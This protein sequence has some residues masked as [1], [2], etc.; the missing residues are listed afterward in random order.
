[1]DKDIFRN[2][3]TQDLQNNIQTY[4][5]FIESIPLIKLLNQKKQLA[6][7]YSLIPQYHPPK[8]YII[9]KG[10]KSNGLYILKKGDV[11]LESNKQY[12]RN[13]SSKDIFGERSLLAQSE[14]NNDVIANSNC[15]VYFV[16]DASLV[17]IFG[18]NMIF[19]LFKNNVTNAF[20]SNPLFKGLRVKYIK[21]ILGLFNI[22]ECR[23][24]EIAYHK[25]EIKSSTV[26][27]IIEGGLYDENK[28]IV[29]KKGEILFDKE[30]LFQSKEVL[31]YDIKADPD[32]LIYEANTDEIISELGMSI[33]QAIQKS[34]TYS[35]KKNNEIMNILS[36]NQL[37]LLV[38]SSEE[39]SFKPKE[40]IFS[41]ESTNN[42]LYFLNSGHVI[43]ETEFF[44]KKEKKTVSSLFGSYILEYQTYQQ[45]A[46]VK[47][48]ANVICL[49]K[50]KLKKILGPNM[51]N[52]FKNIVL[53]R[54]CCFQVTDF[55]FINELYVEN[56][57]K[58]SLVTSSRSN[59]LYGI[60]RMNKKLVVYDG[61]M[62]KLSLEKE[63]LN[64]L[65]HPFVIKLHSTLQVQYFL[66]FLMEYIHGVTLYSII[67]QKN[68]PFFT[69][70]QLKFWFSCLFIAILYI[71]SKQIIFRFLTPSNIIIKE[72]GYLSL[73]NF[74][75]AKIIKEKIK[76]IIG[77]PQYMSPEMLVGEPYSFEVD[78]W[79]IAV[80]MYELAY[81]KVPFGEGVTD[82]IG[83]YFSIINSN[84]NHPENSKDKL[85]FNLLQGMLS[86]NKRGRIEK[87]EDIKGHLWF[88][89]FNW[90]MVEELKYNSEFRPVVE[91]IGSPQIN[92]C[93][94]I[95]QEDKRTI[96]NNDNILF[97][98]EDKKEI[99]KWFEMF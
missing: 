93:Y 68:L 29:A 8:Q 69:S 90:K 72:N 70:S 53:S 12:I 73:I 89:D 80:I 37:E 15:L 25:G 67:H 45:R 17:N 48:K 43:I 2:I 4:L 39:K 44:D 28:K 77:L 13:L 97:D 24:G 31:E 42:I 16:S 94:L 38:N 76:T 27:A 50:E 14:R 83:V 11:Y 74:T 23:K 92:Y 21:Q 52:Y 63:I 49:E 87:K 75:N 26:A 7:C 46:V 84:L 82:P 88:K 99:E 30:I 60:R 95:H 34:K 65:T 18:T 41:Y 55:K 5:H 47:E 54:E 71:H 22:K 1:M 85:L 59:Q 9:T 40:V 36:S 64:S 35:K 61:Y 19:E 57:W 56:I 20:I 6:L 58:V 91:N 66:Y 32:C 79:S 62:D 3:L 10:E 51:Y 78:Y 33:E 86:K 96:P 81:R 98:E